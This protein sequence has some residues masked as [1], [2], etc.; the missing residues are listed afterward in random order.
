M[1]QTTIFIVLFLHCAGLFSQHK[2]PDYKKKERLDLFFSKNDSVN[3]RNENG[4]VRFEHH[5]NEEALQGLTFRDT[6]FYNPLFLPIIFNGKILPLGLNL[7]NPNKNTESGQLINQN[8]TFTPKLNRAKFI[9]SVRRNYYFNYPDRV[10]YSVKDFASNPPQIKGEDVLEGFNPFKDPISSET[11]FSLIVPTIEGAEIKRKYWI[12]TGAN[13]LQFSQNYFSANWHKGGISNM[14]INSL[15][16]ISLNY[17]MNKV[18]FNNILEWQLSV[19]N[20]PED[21]LRKYSIGQ[22]LIRY[23]GD[24][25]I[26]AFIKRWSYSANL[27]ARTQFFNS[28]KSNSTELLS[29]FLAPL[30]VNTGIGFKYELDEKSKKVRHRRLRMKLHLAPISVNFKYVGNDKVDVARFGIEENKKTS[31][32]FGSTIINELT[33]DFNRYINWTSR[34]KFFTNYNNIDSEFENT[35]DMAHTKAFSTRIYLHLRYDDN[36]PKDPRFKYLQVN[37]MLSFGLNYKW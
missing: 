20:A 15:Q 11:S 35:L 16:K 28:H 32:Y 6:L 29:S 7:Y 30:Y 26:D 3:I 17:K 14:N 4:T 2:L 23:F 31:L 27:E 10:N 24:F 12:L 18:R 33:Y 25:G 8:E 34:L 37:E 9:Q 19:F 21:S 36:V 1:R 13:S 22:D 5:Y